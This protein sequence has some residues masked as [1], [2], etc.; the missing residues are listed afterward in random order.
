MP[1]VGNLDS[2]GST[3]KGAGRGREVAADG[4]SAGEVRAWARENGYEVN[5]RGRVP[6]EIQDAFDASH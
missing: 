6:R 1:A 4:P 3:A 2:L 5:D